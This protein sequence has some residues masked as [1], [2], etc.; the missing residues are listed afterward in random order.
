[1]PAKV[2]RDGSVSV[3]GTTVGRVEKVMRTGPFIE[4]IGVRFGFGDGTPQWVPYAADGTKL[5]DGHGTR[6]AAV[7]RVVSHSA[8]LAI[9]KV[10][11]ETSWSNRKFVSAWVTYKGHSFSVSRYAS[12]SQW[13]VDA[14]FAPGAF[15]P[16]WSNGSGTRVTS[17]RVLKDEMHKA[18][19]DAAIAAGVWPI[20]E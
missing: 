2:S 5:T 12:E 1:M 14:Y 4:G 18:A 16:A 15:M 19:T 17:A 6:K 11:L 9:N 3:D 20:A 8:P 7:E 13:V 10:Q